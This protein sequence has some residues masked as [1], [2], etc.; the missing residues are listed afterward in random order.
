MDTQLPGIDRMKN[1]KMRYGRCPY[2]EL[3]LAINPSGSARTEL[4]VRSRFK[5]YNSTK[6]NYFTSIWY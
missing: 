1:Y 4:V 5:R 3:P 2:L 6:R